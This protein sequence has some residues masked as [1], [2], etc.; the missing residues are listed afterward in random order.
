MEGST[1]AAPRVACL[2]CRGQKLKCDRELPACVRCRK[3]GATC[4]YPSP[5]N[6]KQI[7]QNISRSR[8]SLSSRAANEHPAEP[9]HT[10]TS[11]QTQ[12]SQDN[13]ARLPVTGLEQAG[14]DELPSTEIGLLLLEIYFKRIYHATLLF[15]RDLAF[16][17]YRQNGIPT[18]LLRALFAHAATFLEE[19]DSPYKEH[20]KLISV[21]SLFEKSWSWA[22]SSSREV[23]S[24][25]DEPNMLRVQALLA[26]QLYYFS[27][28]E[29]QRAI[30]HASL[31]YRLC[32]LLGYD[33]L[34]EQSTSSL[35]NHG[36]QFDRE[37]KRRYFWGSW[38]GTCIGSLD[39]DRACEKVT[40]LPLP[41]RLEP[42]GSI[43]QGPEF[44]IG[45]LMKIDWR[46]SER[47]ADPAPPSLMAELVRLLGVW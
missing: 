16:Q 1:G 45:P 2:R 13:I 30:V 29:I 32:Q 39:S 43:F 22:R 8:S 46:M 36:L 14:K 25:A 33:R 10:V 42:H 20:T 9:S 6:R 19:V 35:S 23:L 28:K 31:A 11:E 26:L 3:Q 34:Y 41:A 47:Q 24:H 12:H 7:A 40:G 5:P 4:T 27:R 21:N 44:K 38:C 17:L 37:M 15:H 18:Y